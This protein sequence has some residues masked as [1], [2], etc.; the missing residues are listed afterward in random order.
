MAS[1]GLRATELGPVGWLPTDPAALTRALAPHGL[2]LVGG[3]VPF[4]LHT[5][6]AGSAVEAAGRT[7]ATLAAAG[8]EVI[9]AAAVADLDWSPPF[10]LDDTQRGHMAEN[11][12][13]VEEAVN[14]H[15]LTLAVHPHAGTLVERA[16]D[17]ERLLEAT[18]VPFCLDTGHLLI[19][20]YD[21][22][23]FVRDHAG[24]VAHVHL[25]DVDA[26]VAGRLNAGELTLMGAVQAGLFRPLGDGDAGI[27]DVVRRLEA[28]GYERRLVL[29]Q[30]TA[31]TGQEPPVGSGPVLD[32]VRSIEFLTTVA[33]TKEEVM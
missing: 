29:E 23:A 16:E 19:G 32:V 3:F 28:S 22:A 33:P 7:A 18:A 25:K 27:A 12:A 11:L 6:D 14:R 15:G 4:V 17:V 30:D 13:R 2:Q 1:I 31:I 5:A 21:P 8:A 20:G 10:P 24:R 26:K 9:C